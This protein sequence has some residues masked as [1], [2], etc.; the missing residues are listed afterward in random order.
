MFIRTGK[1]YALGYFAVGCCFGIGAVFVSGDLRIVLIIPAVFFV[2]IA[3]W[4]GF[5]YGLMGTVSKFADQASSGGDWPEIPEIT[6]STQREMMDHMF[7]RPTPSLKDRLLA[8][9]MEEEPLASPASETEALEWARSH[10]V[11]FRTGRSRKQSV[12]LRLSPESLPSIAALLGSTDQELVMTATLALMY[13]G[14][15][16]DSDATPTTDPTV[17]RVT[18]PNGVVHTIPAESP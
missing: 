11:G 6:A 1:R 16:M 4:C 15:H 10:Q 9:K 17:Y 2:L 14:A 18:M 3:A 7:P 8:R 13:N 5:V 12:D